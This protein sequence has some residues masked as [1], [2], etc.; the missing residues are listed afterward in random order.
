MFKSKFIQRLAL[1]LS[2]MVFA[3]ITANAQS[4][5]EG[6]DV[7]VPLPTGW[8][9]SNQSTTIGTTGWFQGGTTWAAQAGAATSWI[10]ANFNNTTGS[11]DINN[12]LLTPSRTFKNG[13]VIKFW[14]RT[15]TTSNFPDR[16]EVRLSLNGTSTNVGVGPAAVGDFTTVLLSINPTLTIGGYPNAWTEQTITLS[17][18]PAPTAGRIAF[19]YWVTFAGPLGDNGNIIG[20]DTFSYTTTV[21]P[22]SFP[23]SDFD[24][25]GKSDLSLYRP[26]TGQWFIRQS[27][28]A[29]IVRPFGISTDVITPS[30]FDGDNKTDSAIFRASATPGMSDFYVFRSSD[31]T[32]QGVEWGT[33]GDVPTVTDFDGDNKD[34]FTVYRPSNNGFYVLQSQTATLRFYKFGSPSDKPV[35][36]YFV[37]NDAKA[38]FAVYRPSTGTWWIADSVANTVTNQIWGNATD[39]PVYADYDGD[40]KDDIAVFRPSEGRWYIRNSMAGTIS[41]VDFGTSTDVPVPGDYDGDG[42]YDQAVYRGGS[43]FIRNSVSGAVTNGLFGNATDQPTERG[44]LPQ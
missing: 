23:R 36:G 29:D 43:W 40:A 13:D 33:T 42:K 10:G 12:W 44:Y 24:G 41:Y 31:S 8:V 14:T 35:P 25:D 9:S 32:V 37:G 11:D 7:A 26:S 21:T 27:G 30:D 2:L 38:D 5:S 4:F 15:A 17:G 39:I 3:G 1:A 16:L 18:I 28:G 6:F 20:I 34:D 22:T 19:R